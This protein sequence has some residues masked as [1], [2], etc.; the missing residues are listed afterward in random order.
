MEYGEA[1]SDDANERAFQTAVQQLAHGRA[2]LHRLASE[3]VARTY[4]VCVV[5]GEDA[6]EG[7]LSAI[8][9]ELIE[10]VERRLRDWVHQ[11]EIL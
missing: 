11:K 4:C 6:A 7:R 5:D 10:S 1:I 2:D 8:H 9:A 3:A